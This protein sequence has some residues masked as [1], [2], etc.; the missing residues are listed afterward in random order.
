M[1]AETYKATIGFFDAL[2]RLLHPFMPFITEELW[3]HIG[4]RREGESIMYASMPEVKGV[5]SKVLSDM[6][7]A[8]EI[9]NG[10]RGIRAQRNIPNREELQLNVINADIPMKAIVKK[11]GNLSGIATVDTKDAAAAT[12]MVDT[13]EFNIPLLNNI[14]VEAELEKLNKELTYLQGFRTSVEKKLSNERFVNNAPA[15]VVDGERKKLADAQ[16]KIANL[17]AS[18]AALKA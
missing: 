17:E 5:D 11:L 9:I 10:I 4:D 8:K 6:E 13:T 1:D 3:Q 14:D 7:T 15:A 16:A 2:L 12:F 18:I